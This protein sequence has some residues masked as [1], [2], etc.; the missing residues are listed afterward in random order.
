MTDC[1]LCTKVAMPQIVRKYF[2]VI[3]TVVVT[4]KVLRGYAFAGAK[5]TQ[6]VPGS[7]R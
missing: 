1:Q 7:S 5:S 6:A 3:P 2:Y 4:L